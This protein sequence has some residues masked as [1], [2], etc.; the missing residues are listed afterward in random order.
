MQCYIKEGIP[1]I[2]SS[3]PVSQDGRSQLTLEQL[4]MPGMHSFCRLFPTVS[5]ATSFYYTWYCII[6][7][8]LG[9]TEILSSD[10]FL[11]RWLQPRN[12]R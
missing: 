1:G 8:L 12:P 10:S 7:H 9:V 2:P 5:S 4:K 6:L 3:V 11:M